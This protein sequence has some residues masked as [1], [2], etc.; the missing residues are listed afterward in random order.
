[1]VL[2]TTK[3]RQA[4]DVGFGCFLH[5]M[6]TG[7]RALVLV[8][9]KA[10]KTELSTAGK[11]FRS[12]K[13]RSAG[14][15]RE[16]HACIA[17]AIAEADSALQGKVPGILLSRDV[18]Y[19]FSTEIAYAWKLASLGIPTALIYLVSS[20]IMPSSLGQIACGRQVIG[21]RR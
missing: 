21:N 11:P 1:L 10:H 4:A 17:L 7:C 12:A 9:A 16:N 2:R 14:T 20:A 6:P 19:Q 5:A 18:S 15:V 3:S 13:T 8:E